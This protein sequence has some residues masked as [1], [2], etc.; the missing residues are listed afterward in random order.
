MK[1]TEKKFLLKGMLKAFREVIIII[2]K[3]TIDL[4]VFESTLLWLYYLL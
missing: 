3:I 2:K 4:G 1:D